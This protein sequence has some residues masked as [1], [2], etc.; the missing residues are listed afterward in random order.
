MPGDG[1]TFIDVPQPRDNS[2]FGAMV[3]AMRAKGMLDA[4]N[5]GTLFISDT[6]EIALDTGSLQA[7][8][9][10]AKTEAIAFASLDEAISLGSVTVDHASG[11]GLFAVSALD[12]RSIAESRRLLVIFATNAQNTGMR[13]ANVSERIIDTYGR[14]PVRIEPET[15]GVSLAG[16]GSWRLSPVGLDGTVYPAI[17][18]GQ[19]KLATRL[20]N[21]QPTGP[22]TYFLVERTP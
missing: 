4:R 5:D 10:T 7:T 8:V 15:I 9:R 14:L 12:G 22:T 13:F 18:S 3:A 21:D 1:K 17:G 16:T 20:S 11:R 6:G 2:S 19:G